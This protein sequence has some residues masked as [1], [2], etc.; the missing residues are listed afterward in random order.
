MN[1][2]YIFFSLAF[3]F[4]CSMLLILP[5]DSDC[6]PHAMI[7]PCVNGAVCPSER[8]RLLS[9]T[10]LLFFFPP[11]LFQTNWEHARAHTHGQEESVG[12]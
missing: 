5:S 11:L 2:V 3:Y 1:D 8:P 12:N 10:Y 9:F 7:V 6:F 4:L